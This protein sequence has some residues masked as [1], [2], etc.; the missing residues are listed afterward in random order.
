MRISPTNLLA[1]T[2]PLLMLL[3]SCGGDAPDAAPNANSDVA[4]ESEPAPTANVRGV[5]DTEIVL[6][7][8]NDLSGP[9]ALLG[10]AAIN[11][12]RMRF[13]EA[14]A[15]GGIHGRQIRFIVEDQQYQVPRAI[16]AVNKLI[17][18]DQVFAI[19]L[20]MGTPMNNAIIPT[21]IE[22]NV[23]NL[24]PISG[25]RSMV[26]P[27]RPLQ[28]AARGIYY[29][30]IRAAARYYIERGAKKPCV[31]YQDTDYGQE[32]LDGARDQVAAMGMQLASES[33]HKPTDSE[34]TSAILRLKGAG[35][36]LVLMGTVHRDTILIF[37]AAR[38]MGWTDVQWAGNNAA[39]SQAVADLESGASEG[40]ASFVHIGLV[41]RDDPNMSPDVAAWWDAYVQ[42][43]GVN[44]EYAAFEG[45][46]NADLVVRGLENAGRDLT[47][48]KLVAGIEAL[49]EVTDR[50]GYR[51]SFGPE[52]H[53][54]VDQSVLSKVV[55]GR[56]V[57]QDESVSY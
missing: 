30:E 17:N 21:L 55:A 45:Y 12:A 14:N 15:A 2:L 37:E 47:P 42:R 4:T 24:F 27:F 34:F 50:F 39:Y 56:W 32:I 35:C 28:F 7:S 1:A 44:P 19:L 48:E 13:D 11:G 23:P 57:T 22:N 25:A 10:V 36:D 29:D 46:R 18:R 52:D 5:S 3:A 33:A 26:E 43:Y 6:G 49:G 53:E 31:I 8:P 20:S 9:T 41:Y 38:K 51:L 16:Q 40:Y 54:G